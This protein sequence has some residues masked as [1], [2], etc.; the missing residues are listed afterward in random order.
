MTWMSHGCHAGCALQIQRWT[1]NAPATLID[2]SMFAEDR[3]ARY[4]YREADR[5]HT[6]ASIQPKARLGIFRKTKR[7]QLCSHLRI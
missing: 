3:I 5:E 7:Q 2:S 1:V 6:E 4:M